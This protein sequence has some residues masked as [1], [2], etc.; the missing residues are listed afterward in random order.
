[1]IATP[2]SNQS[3][4]PASSPVETRDL[5]RLADIAVVGRFAGHLDGDPREHGEARQLLGR[6][7]QAVEV[8]ERRGR[9]RGP[10][11]VVDEAEPLQA[12]VADPGGEEDGALGAAVA[13]CRPARPERDAMRRRPDGVDPLPG[14][15]DAV[16]VPVG[17]VQD[18]LGRRDLGWSERAVRGDH[19]RDAAKRR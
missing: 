5:E 3:R 13:E 14:D 1:M 12:G 15:I 10:P 19:R 6:Q 16:V 7:V 2:R 18:E 4:S 11:G 17:R 9:G 8:G